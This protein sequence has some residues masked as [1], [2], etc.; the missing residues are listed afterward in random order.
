MNISNKENIYLIIIN[1]WVASNIQSAIMG[2][3]PKN[4]ICFLF[5]RDITE[6]ASFL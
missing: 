3:K 6:K 2:R 5:I 1:M 4:M